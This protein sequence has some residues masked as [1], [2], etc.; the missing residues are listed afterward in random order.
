MRRFLYGVALGALCGAALVLA[1]A[2]A[3]VGPAAAAPVSGTPAPEREGRKDLQVRVTPEMVRYSNTRYVLY[4]ARALVDVLA[5]VALLRLGISARARDAAD[6]T[7]RN[8][9]A[10]AYV[11]YPL[12]MLAYGALTLPLTLYASYFLPHQYGLSTQSL[13]G[14]VLD[15][16]KRFA[17]GSAVAPPIVALLY[18][19]LRRSPAR[20]W[21]G[22]WLAL[23]PLL[24]LSVL[25]VPIFVEPLFNRFQPLR[26]EQLRDRLLAMAQRAGIEQ[27][28]VFEVD[29]S[30]RTKGVNAYVTGLGG[31]ARIVMWDTLL[32]RL[33]EDEVVFVMAHE[34]GHYVEGHV[35]LGLALAIAGSFGVLLLADRGSKALIGRYGDRWQVRGLDDLASLPVLLLV[36]SVVNFLGSPVESAISR[37]METRADQFAL[38]LTRE[39]E[40]GA[41]S[42]IKLAELNLSNPSP[43]EFV[44]FWM[45]SHP[46]LKQRIQ[47]ALEWKPE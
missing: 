46:P 23:I 40:T 11:Y 35:P 44:V 8:G 2:T 42:Y 12:L 34:M 21:V 22:F 27:S 17:I 37:T 43:P 14:W 4:F 32:Q 24:T 39:P 5:L 10:R 26:N 3:V 15:A 1:V 45:F 7:G 33:D 19:S 28:R 18:W 20:W 47:R 6:R 38:R 30:V 25:L 41:S 36:V 13:G 29:A 31:S 9:L 16:T